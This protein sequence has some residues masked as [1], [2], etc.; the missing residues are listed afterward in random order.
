M[1][2]VM[3]D[4][5]RVTHTLTAAGTASGEPATPA[6][7]AH[8]PADSPYFASAT[9]ERRHPA[10]AALEWWWRRTAPLGAAPDARFGEK[11]WARRGLV[12]STLL[13]A[14]TLLSLAGLVATL[15]LTVTSAPP[16]SAM[17]PFCCLLALAVCAAALLLNRRGH[18]AAA[19]LVLVA[20]T[21]AALC[22]LLLTTTGTPSAPLVQAFIVSTLVAVVFFAPWGA[23]P[24]AALNSTLLVAVSL[25]SPTLVAGGWLD[26]SQIA[27]AIGS[28][29]ALA[30]VS[31]L[32]LQSTSAARR[33]AEAAA[34]VAE[35]E[36]RYAAEQ[37]LVLLADA[38]QIG[39]AL[40]TH[41]AGD[42]SV[43]VPALES[44]PLGRVGARLN[45]LFDWFQRASEL[46]QHMNQVDDDARRLVDVLKTLRAG[47]DPVWP[48]PSGSPLDAVFDALQGATAW[49][50]ETP[51]PLPA[52]VTPVLLATDDADAGTDDGGATDTRI[53]HRIVEEYSGGRRD[54]R[55]MRLVGVSLSDVDLPG[56]DLRDANLIGAGLDDADLSDADLSGAILVRAD[57]SGAHLSGA[58]LT[59]ATLVGA[60][61]VT[62]NLSAA[63]CTD[64]NLA[65]ADLSG[66]NLHNAVL[67]CAVLDEADLSKA[68]LHGADLSGANLRRARLS[69]ATLVAA[70]LQNTHL[71]GAKLTAASLSMAD[72][73]GANLA[74]ADL[75]SADL[76]DADI[77]G[78]T[79]SGAD[80]S[81]TNL[82]GADLRDAILDGADLRGAHWGGANLTGARL[83]GAL[84]DDSQAMRSRLELGS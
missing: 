32:V 81:D 60:R 20:M 11:E 48:D 42:Y 39:G 41:A 2:Q 18:V 69:A 47:R 33:E 59:G 40:E 15:A 77:S 34:L 68:D 65:D 16:I 4:G 21:D 78:A 72:L 28:Q 23:L 84:L 3:E 19:G 27:S 14:L 31:A 1:R 17:D 83:D 56:V 24:V 5:M 26:A 63:D 71:D 49:D 7:A 82:E 52:P 43:R 75:H 61:L 58:R 25:L 46:R 13:L 76:S 70:K 74:D 53:A 30:G 10:R 64:A 57:L 62:A 8:R 45:S 38:Q 51:V 37:S 29:L 80:L 12:G 9:R 50:N 79:L 36:W 67:T 44:G 35:A 66:A 22:C 6:N 54:F 73:H 55:G